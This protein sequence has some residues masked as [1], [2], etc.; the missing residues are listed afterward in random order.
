ME[1]NKCKFFN[2]L[3]CSIPYIFYDNLPFRCLHNQGSCELEIRE[4]G[5]RILSIQMGCKQKLACENN[6]RQNFWGRNPS[7][8]QCRPEPGHVHS[9]KVLF[10][11]PFTWFSPNWLVFGQSGRSEEVFSLPFNYRRT[12]HFG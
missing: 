4:R 3:Y 2:E 11:D 5:G 10:C 6:K 12:P 8:T 1:E 9:G 7:Y